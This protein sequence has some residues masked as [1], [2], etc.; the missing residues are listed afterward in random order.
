VSPRPVV[1]AVAAI[2]LTA[3]SHASAQ[4]IPNINAPK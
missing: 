3:A 2:L 4:S 1:A